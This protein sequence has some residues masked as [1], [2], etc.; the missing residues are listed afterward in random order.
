MAS[1]IEWFF[2]P[3]FPLA[4]VYFEVCLALTALA[5]VFHFRRLKKARADRVAVRVY[6]LLFFTLL[7]GV[8]CLLI[9]L[10]AEE[11]MRHLASCG[12]TFGRADQGFLFLLAGL[13]L[14]V[15]SGMIGARNPEMIK[16]YPLSKEATANVRTFI[17]YEISYLLL[18][19]L[20][21]EFLYR[22]ILL[23]PL[24]PALGP[25]PA[26][27]VQTMISTLYHLG[28]PEMEIY[29]AAAAGL[30]FGGIAIVTGSFL[31]TFVLHAAAG[32]STDTFLFIRAR[33][34]ET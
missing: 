20:P 32:I 7:L 12:W 24:V 22:G 5:S 14:A 23:F 3:S 34:G 30:L 6:F 16:F 18:Y 4:L 1:W 28:H 13:P 10:T 25:L 8:P 21:W 27:A 31:Y 33:K 17:A 29:A 11:P 26:I 2:G 9:A 15:L 19:Y